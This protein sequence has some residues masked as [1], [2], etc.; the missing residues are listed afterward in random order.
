MPQ[1]LSILV[2]VALV[3]ALFL[4]SAMLGQS[5]FVYYP[6]RRVAITPA[7]LGMPFEDVRIPTADGEMLAAWYVPA[8]AGQGGGTAPTVLHCHGNAGSNANRVGL[9]RTLH[10]LGLNVLLFDYRGYGV[11]TGK[12]DEEGTYRDA[13]ACWKYLVEIR[14]IPPGRIIIHGQSLGGAV[15]AQ[16]AA[17]VQPGMLILEST[18]TSAVDMAAR[19]F[20]LLPARLVCRFSY[21]SLE[22][23][24]RV[25]C[26]VLVAHSPG[27]EMIPY[28]YGRRLFEAASEP[29]VFVEL[30]GDH[31]AGGIETSESYR[32]ALQE[33]MRR[34][35]AP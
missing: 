8:P 10:D 16:L 12:P 33:F 28:R 26:P 6:D 21:D 34:H 13:E 19:M 14:K 5:R 30:A 25:K 27:D 32:A 11:S 20:P 2:V 9:A 17:T 22:R 15:G 4:L 3:Y 24:S 1:I 18:F 29:K 23:V 35:M 31:N 7:A